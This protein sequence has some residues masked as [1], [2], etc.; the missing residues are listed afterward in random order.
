MCVKYCFGFFMTLIM[1]VMPFGMLY[2]AKP[3]VHATDIVYPEGVA[4]YQAEKMH[5]LFVDDNSSV[6]NVIANQVEV[7]VL[8]NKILFY[9]NPDLEQSVLD[10]Y[11][12]RYLDRSLNPLQWK[13][14]KD[15]THQA[16]FVNRGSSR[17]FFIRHCNKNIEDKISFK[18]Y[19]YQSGIY[20]L[21]GHR[22]NP[23]N[24]MFTDAKFAGFVPDTK[25]PNCK[26]LNV[27]G[28][29][30]I[31]VVIT[32]KRSVF[33][34][35][36]LF[37]ISPEHWTATDLSGIFL[38]GSFLLFLLLFGLYYKFRSCCCIYDDEEPVTKV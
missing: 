20:P 16:H 23:L 25:D 27:R 19:G 29:K 18:I 31:S 10:K 11:R 34:E 22:K 24:M 12:I 17:G 28:I 30:K 9:N 36:V 38:I 14:Y 37:D 26:V 35:K 4:E 8:G 5:H 15:Y 13:F 32:A 2:L 21:S 7:T 33:T 3:V 6:E 1:I